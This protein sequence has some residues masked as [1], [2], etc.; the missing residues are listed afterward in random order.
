MKKKEFIASALQIIR[1]KGPHPASVKVEDIKIAGDG[2]TATVVAT[3]NEKSAMEIKN[4]DDGKAGI[5]AVS[6]TSYCSETLQL[7]NEHII[8]I[9]SEACST[10]VK[11]V[12]SF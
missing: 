9:Q 11:P 4:P 5:S 6:A 10:E 7:S 8:Q 2:H 1:E 12:D 3:I